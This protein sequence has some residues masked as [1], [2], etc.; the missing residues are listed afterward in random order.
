MENYANLKDAWLKSRALGFLANYAKNHEGDIPSRDAF[1]IVDEFRTSSD[2]TKAMSERFSGEELERVV[3]TFPRQSM[4]LFPWR[5]PSSTLVALWNCGIETDRAREVVRSEIAA[6][7]AVADE[8]GGEEGA[9]TERFG[10]LCSILALDEVESEVLFLA[11]LVSRGYLAWPA[12]HHGFE[13]LPRFR[14]QF[15]AQCLDREVDVVL[16]ATSSQGRLRLNECLEQALDYNPD[17][18]R[19][20]DGL[21]DDPFVS[22]FFKHYADAPVP[23]G[24]FGDLGEKHGELVSR[25]V[26]TAGEGGKAPNIL[27]HGQPGFGRAR[28]ARAVAAHT[29][30]ECYFVSASDYSSSDVRALETCNSLFDPKRTLLVIGDAEDILN[31]SRWRLKR[32]FDEMRIPAIW[33]VDDEI[34]GNLD[35]SVRRRFDYS[36]RF[37]SAAQEE[38]LRMW[39]DASAR[40]GLGDLLDDDALGRFAAKHDLGLG[41]IEAVIGTVA[42]LR[43]SKAEAAPLVET[44]LAQRE[45]LATVKARG[46]APS[47][48][49]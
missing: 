34:V 10:R 8:Q 11:F 6:A 13:S 5:L 18:D 9:F 44:L 42:R 33:I 36:V 27:L 26:S 28:F 23:W 41:E 40:L 12:G 22:R 17:L 39:R 43:P 1:D 21:S 30:R 46:D 7:R 32:V 47:R 24:R 16:K 37:A 38:R 25:L 3:A 49:A 2:V 19:F 20:L 15:I 4:L 45:E 31:L 48:Q 14:A 35:P 29:G